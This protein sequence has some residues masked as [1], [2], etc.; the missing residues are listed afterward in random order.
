MFHATITIVKRVCVSYFTFFEID[1][2]TL[3]VK[4]AKVRFQRDLS[5]YHIAISHDGGLFCY[6]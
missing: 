6:L 5:P 1:F 2:N 4:N 3:L